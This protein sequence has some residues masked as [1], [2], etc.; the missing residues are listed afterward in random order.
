MALSKNT[1]FASP[2][3]SVLVIQTA[4][5]GSVDNDVTAGANLTL[6]VMEVVNLSNAASYTK[7][8]DAAT[9]T[10]GTTAPELIFPVGAGATRTLNVMGSGHTFATGICL[11][12]VTTGGTGGTTDPSGGDVKV[13]IITS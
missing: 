12:T 4:S 1:G 11:A 3:G 13:S 7:L 8:Y 2:L 6:N 10:V 5:T 9:A